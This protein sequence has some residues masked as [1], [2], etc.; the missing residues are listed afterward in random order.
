MILENCKQIKF[1]NLEHYPIDV[2][3]CAVGYESRCVELARR[4]DL[5]NLRKFA[6]AFKSHL[7]EKQRNDNNKIFSKLGYKLVPA[8]G[9]D[10]TVVHELLETICSESRQ[11]TINLLVDYSCMT[12]VWYA[13]ILYYFNTTLNY[14]KTINIFFSYSFSKFS[15]ALDNLKYN[16]VVGPI[17]GF[18]NFSI[19][20]K[21]TSLILGLGYEKIRS[22]G[23]S[24][25]LDA[26][27]FIF[28]TKPEDGNSEYS[29]EVERQ[30]KH[31]ISSIKTENIYQ[32]PIS[33]LDTTIN[34]I[35]TLCIDLI[36]EH[37]VVLAPCGPKPFSLASLIVGSKLK[38]IDVWR[39][40]SGSEGNVYNREFNGNISILMCSYV[41]ER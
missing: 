36:D 2:V 29:F 20:D 40:S 28:Y 37:R 4:L 31:L 25:Y 30:N 34:L 13:Y 15:P 35:Y 26:E 14:N 33:N 6:L 9:E 5:P 7:D 18:C 24:E 39:V 27:T 10:Y 19:P 32:Y 21:S 22:F 38:E 23:L 12:R 41:N 8:G 1:E 16:L 17:Y 3:L 11:S